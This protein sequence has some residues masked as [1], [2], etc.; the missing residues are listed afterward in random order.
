MHSLSNRLRLA[1]KKRMVEWQLCEFYV[2]VFRKR[3]QGRKHQYYVWTPPSFPLSVSIAPTMTI[4]LRNGR[5]FRLSSKQ[6]IFIP[7][8]DSGMPSQTGH[9]ECC[10]R[11]QRDTPGLSLLRSEF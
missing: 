7:L 5:E 11:T 3:M 6:M 1:W 2:T 4:Y 9:T 10:L 8:T